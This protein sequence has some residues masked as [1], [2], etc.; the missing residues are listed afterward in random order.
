MLLDHLRKNKSVFIFILISA[1]AFFVGINYQ[2]LIE[3]KIFSVAKGC[4]EFGM[5]Q[6]FC[7]QRLVNIFKALVL[8]LFKHFILFFV[9]SLHWFL[10]P[11]SLLNLFC[12]CFKCGLSFSYCCSVLGIKGIFQCLILLLA[13]F[14]IIA[15]SVYFV[16]LVFE[17]RRS[18][19]ACLKNTFKR[20][21]L[22]SVCLF[23]VISV[24]FVFIKISGMKICGIANI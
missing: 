9:G 23:I 18:D 2:Y 3:S 19:G 16:K 17:Q 4:M 15:W 24:I 5:L 10:F 20:C 13:C 11:I 1:V 21:A 6:L 14:T 7:G 12:L 8:S 22:I